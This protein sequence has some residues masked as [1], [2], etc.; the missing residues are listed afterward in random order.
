MGPVPKHSTFWD[1][2]HVMRD[3]SHLF[4]T[5]PM[6][7]GTGPICMGP[8]LPYQVHMLLR[9]KDINKNSTKNPALGTGGNLVRKNWKSNQ[10]E[11]ILK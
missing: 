3:W 10:N 2:S 7:L 8:V 1:Q 6:L 5:G 9:N 4:E 11:R